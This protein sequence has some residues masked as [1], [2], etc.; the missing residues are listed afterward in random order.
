[1]FYFYSLSIFLSSWTVVR[2]L[3]ADFVNASTLRISWD[4]ASP[5][6]NVTGYDVI[7]L[8]DNT[9]VSRVAVDNS[10]SSIVVLSLDQCNNYTVEVAAN[11]SV[12]PG[13]YSTFEFV[14]RCGESLVVLHFLSCHNFRTPCSQNPILNAVRPRCPAMVL[15]IDNCLL[16]KKSPLEGI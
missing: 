16:F 1:M 10:T 5:D 4:E 15:E 12:G 14:T 9:S 7:V 3:T 8:K 13:N 6:Q 11:S 2:G